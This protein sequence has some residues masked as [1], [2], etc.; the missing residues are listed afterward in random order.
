MTNKVK[1]PKK[2]VP[3]S[4][5]SAR[6][7]KILQHVLSPLEAVAFKNAYKPFDYELEKGSNIYIT[8]HTC[9]Q[10]LHST[11]HK[12]DLLLNSS[13]KSIYFNRVPVKHRVAF[14][15]VKIILSL[16][17]ILRNK[18]CQLGCYSLFCIMKRGRKY[19]AEEQGFGKGE[20]QTI[21]S[22]FAKY[23]CSHL[24]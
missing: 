8:Q 12:L 23:K 22:L 9:K 15:D 1:Q 5:K 7:R 20:M 11:S 4:L 13:T 10:L 6:S 19:F 24:F 14:D 17:P 2:G 16:Y 18:L 21:D 3:P